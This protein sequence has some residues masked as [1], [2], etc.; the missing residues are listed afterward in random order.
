[1]T[2]IGVKQI[3]ASPWPACLGHACY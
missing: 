2:P 1:L 3:S